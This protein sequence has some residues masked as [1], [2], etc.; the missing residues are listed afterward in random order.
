M[1]DHAKA[2]KASPFWSPSEWIFADWSAQE[3]IELKHMGIRCRLA[4]K[5]VLMGIDYVQSLFRGFPPAEVPMLYI[6]HECRFVIEQL[7]LYRW[8]THPDGKINKSGK[9]LK[10][11]DDGPD[12]LRYSL[13]SFKH[14]PHAKY[15]VKRVRG[16]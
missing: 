12:A 16:I 7:G 11:D 4:Q 13:F 10:V 8:P 9:P 1:A 2:I 5:D 6:W 14:K 3:R 15:R